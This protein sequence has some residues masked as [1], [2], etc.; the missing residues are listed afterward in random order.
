MRAAN[1]RALPTLKGNFEGWLRAILPA[2]SLTRQE[3]SHG[4]TEFLGSVCFRSRV[5]VLMAT[6][7][8]VYR[9]YDYRE[10]PE[11]GTK[12]SKPV[13]REKEKSLICSVP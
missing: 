11:L 1:I 3:R 9:K 5:P 12:R 6:P 10:R 2:S 8:A 13:H 4:K 7:K